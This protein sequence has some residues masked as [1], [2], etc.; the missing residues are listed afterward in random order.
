[1]MFRTIVGT[2]LLAQRLEIV[3]LPC[4]RIYS[5]TNLSVNNQGKF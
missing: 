3:S 2:K 1:M 4:V 5:L